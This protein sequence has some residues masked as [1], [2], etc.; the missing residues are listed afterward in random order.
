MVNILCL[1]AVKKLMLQDCCFMHSFHALDLI[2][3]SGFRQ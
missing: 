3:C 2:H 1:F